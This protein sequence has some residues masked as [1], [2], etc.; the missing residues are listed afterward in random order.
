MR[1]VRV[2]KETVRK[3]PSL[4]S[5]GVSIF[6]I[7]LL[8]V[9]VCCLAFLHIILAANIFLAFAIFCFAVLM[10]ILWPFV[11]ILERVIAGYTLSVKGTHLM[12]KKLGISKPLNINRLQLSFDMNVVT[13]TDG[14][15]AVPIYY[16]EIEDEKLLEF[17]DDVFL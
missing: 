4:V 3:G 13:L 10:I 11:H 14:I 15:T 17:L 6:I 2:N 7:I 5:L 12:Y 9:L 8:I 16:D 1:V